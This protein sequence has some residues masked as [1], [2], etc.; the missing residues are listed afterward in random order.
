MLPTV[1]PRPIARPQS[2][3]SRQAAPMSV[4]VAEPGQDPIVEW[5]RAILDFLRRHGPTPR[6]GIPAR[7]PVTRLVRDRLIEGLVQ[8]GTVAL[9]G[10]RVAAVRFG[11]P[12]T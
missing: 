4:H 5:R 7:W 10:G 8:E 12:A 6:E 2:G 11:Q 1:S 9:A 3:Q